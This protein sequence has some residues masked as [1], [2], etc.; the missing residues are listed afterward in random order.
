MCSVPEL[1]SRLYCDAFVI[2]ICHKVYTRASQNRTHGVAHSYTPITQ[3]YIHCIDL[4]PNDPNFGVLAD[5][6]AMAAG[7]KKFNCGEIP[8]FVVQ[9]WRE[10]RGLDQDRYVARDPCLCGIGSTQYI[11]EPDRCYTWLIRVNLLPGKT[12]IALEIASALNNATCSIH[13][14]WSAPGS[15]LDQQQDITGPKNA[16]VVALPE[17]A[18]RFWRNHARAKYR[19]ALE[20]VVAQTR[21]GEIAH[22]IASAYV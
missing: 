2:S 4:P 9:W 1:A 16:C 13:E 14:L 8:R 20:R 10:K 12:V 11:H 5:Q 22:H 21:L 3:G 6:C 19:H 18:R 7:V 15:Q 17:H